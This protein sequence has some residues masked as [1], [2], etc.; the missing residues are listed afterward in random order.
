MISKSNGSGTRIKRIKNSISR[1]RSVIVFHRSIVLPIRF[2]EGAQ[3][4]NWLIDQNNLLIGILSPS[5][6]NGRY[7]SS[8]DSSIMISSSGGV[9]TIAT[10]SNNSLPA[11][12]SSIEWNSISTVS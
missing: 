6:R 4:G 2:K 7:S 8:V 3:F 1:I 5:P 9:A 11:P 10:N 12:I